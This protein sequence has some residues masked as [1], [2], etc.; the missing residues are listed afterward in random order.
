MWENIHVVPCREPAWLEGLLAGAPLSDSLSEALQKKKMQ[1][2]DK[3][4]VH[5]KDNNILEKSEEL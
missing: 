3:N 1:A 5:E 4:D 2:K